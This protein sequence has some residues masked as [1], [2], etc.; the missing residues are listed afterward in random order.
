MIRLPFWRRRRLVLVAEILRSVKA[1]VTQTIFFFEAIFALLA[2]KQ[3]EG[4][5]EGEWTHEEKLQLGW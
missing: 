3:H 4:Q 5:E 1:F 2:H